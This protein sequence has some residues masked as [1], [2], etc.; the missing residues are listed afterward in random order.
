MR[1]KYCALV[2]NCDFVIAAEE[3]VFGLSEV[4]F[5]VL[6]AVDTTWSVAHNC[7]R[8]DMAGRYKIASNQLFSARCF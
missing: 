3:I 7:N 2:G 4:N 1:A 5:G 6:P 8:K